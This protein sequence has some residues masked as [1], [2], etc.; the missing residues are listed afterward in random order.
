MPIHSV[1]AYPERD[2]Q[3]AVV[4]TGKT[5][6]TASGNFQGEPLVTKARSEASAVRQWQELAEFRYRIS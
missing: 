1:E 5:T 2:C 4:K 6:W 3:V